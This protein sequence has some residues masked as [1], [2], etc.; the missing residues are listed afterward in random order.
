MGMLPGVGKIKNRI[1][2]ANIDD[3]TIARQQ[4]VI[5]SMTKDER[6]NP[7]KINGSRRKRIAAGC[8]QEFRTS[9]GC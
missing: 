7:K 9:T 5:R 8:G 2:E 4:A 6:L 1:G 3:R